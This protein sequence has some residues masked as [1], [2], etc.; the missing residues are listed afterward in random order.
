MQYI[1]ATQLLLFIIE[2]NQ[3]GQSVK[4]QKKKHFLFRQ[5]TVYVLVHKQGQTAHRGVAM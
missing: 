1:L 4:L 5:T 2:H 3:L